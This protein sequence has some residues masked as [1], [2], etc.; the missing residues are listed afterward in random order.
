MDARQLA[1]TTGVMAASVWRTALP[2]GGGAARIADGP[3]TMVRPV[4]TG[5]LLYFATPGFVFR[6]RAGGNVPD[7]V[8]QANATA[9]AADASGAYAVDGMT[10]QLVHGDAAGG[11]PRVVAT[12]PAQRSVPML[13]VDAEHVYLLLRHGDATCRTTLARVPK[14]G[15]ELTAL[16]TEERCGMDLVV[17]P[18]H[19]YWMGFES[20]GPI[21]VLARVPKAGGSVELLAGGLPYTW[22]LAQNS[23]HVFWTE[24]SP[25]RVLRLAK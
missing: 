19:V 8:L 21:T 3:V 2:L 22:N 7:I 9:L 18:T 14:A 13:G 15:G 20:G 1:W 12:L 16:L 6:L 25:S 10:G 17:D 11:E 4:A 24:P 23:T 5:G